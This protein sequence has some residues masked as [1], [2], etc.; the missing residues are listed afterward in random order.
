MHLNE[1]CTVE[2]E[3]KNQNKTDSSWKFV[4]CEFMKIK[5][6]MRERERDEVINISSLEILLFKDFLCLFFFSQ[7][8]H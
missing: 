2:M 6:L 1:N 5:I 7:I 8:V 3:N 4:I